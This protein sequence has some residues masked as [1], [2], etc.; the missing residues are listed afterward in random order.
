ML[1]E[2]DP[3]IRITVAAL[4]TEFGYDVTEAASAAD[5]LAAV[6]GGAD[7]LIADLN[8]PD[9]SGLDLAAEAV[10]CCPGVGVIIATGEGEQP[11][12]GYLWLTKPF[13]ASRLHDA[14]ARAISA[15]AAR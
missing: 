15:G 8:L 4:V 7:L 9:G 10:A 6:K 12:T 11:E 2:D 14:I 3:L 13:T 1:A 5:A